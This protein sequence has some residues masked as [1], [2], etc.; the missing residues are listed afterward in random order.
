M[1]AQRAINKNVLRD[2][3]KH[4]RVLSDVIVLI[5]S[6]V[7]FLEPKSRNRNLKRYAFRYIMQL[8]K[9]TG[10][11]LGHECFTPRFTWLSVWRASEATAPYNCF[12]NFYPQQT[13]LRTPLS[14]ATSAWFSVTP[15]YNLQLLNTHPGTQQPYVFP[16]RLFPPIV[17]YAK[18]SSCKRTSVPSRKIRARLAPARRDHRK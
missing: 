11:I 5:S 16:S 7:T 13:N 9:P 10:T 4:V 8:S 3:S 12:R 1:L 18:E 17:Y 14:E 15:L 6:H 2:V